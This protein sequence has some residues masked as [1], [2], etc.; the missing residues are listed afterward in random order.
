VQG[1]GEREGTGSE[2]VGEHKG[3]GSA[4]QGSHAEKPGTIRSVILKAAVGCTVAR[5]LEWA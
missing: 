5:E 3:T 4:T 1:Y 2:S